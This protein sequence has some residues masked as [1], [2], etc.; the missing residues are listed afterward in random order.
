[1]SGT[2]GGTDDQ[3]LSTD[4]AIV[5]AREVIERLGPI[6]DR[7]GTRGAVAQYEADLDNPAATRAGSSLAGTTGPLPRYLPVRDL[8]YI[9]FNLHRLAIDD[10]IPRR[11]A[12]SISLPTD[13]H[14]THTV[15][16]APNLHIM[17]DLMARY[18]NVMLPWFRRRIEVGASEL[19]FIYAPVTPLGRIE[20]LSTEV[21]LAKIHRIIDMFLASDVSAARVHFALRPVSDLA[22]LTERFSCPVTVGGGETHIAVPLTLSDKA[23]AHHD[24]V[25]WA[26]GLARCE[27]D[28]RLLEQT[29]LVG[30]V[31]DRVRDALK[32]GRVTKLGETAVALGLSQRSLV[33]ALTAAGMTHHLIVEQERSLQ[34][35]ILLKEATLSLAEIADRLGFPDQSSFGRKCLGWFGK[36]PARLR[37]DLTGG[38]G[39]PGQ[40]MA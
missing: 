31:R 22:V 23:S 3:T 12:R 7:L 40:K 28:I 18:G 30:R 19:R 20:S 25:L 33:R 11:Q 6:A 14:L 26:E 2:I 36:S 32:K 8:V 39:K 35:R 21:S 13:D 38:L 4:A 5:E 1:M 17:L 15:P 27:A 29:P 10:T 24:P 37:L 34:A 9:S 16:Y